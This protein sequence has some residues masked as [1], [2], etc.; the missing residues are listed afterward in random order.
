MNNS[1]HYSTYYKEFPRLNYISGFLLATWDNILGPTVVK[2][3]YFSSLYHCFFSL[4]LWGDVTQAQDDMV[5]YL[6]RNTL[7]SEVCKPSSGLL[8][9]TKV[10]LLRQP[11]IIFS[12]FNI[13][14]NSL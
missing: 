5:Q 13:P 11:G 6:I 14:I 8:I 7:D 1:L 12:S 2:V 9:E 3:W 10:N 4:Q